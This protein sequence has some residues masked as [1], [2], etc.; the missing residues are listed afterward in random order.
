MTDD[1]HDLNGWIDVRC[2]SCNKLLFRARG[3]GCIIEV[4]CWNR[5]CKALVQ[6]P[7]SRMAEVVLQ[8]ERR[9]I[10]AEPNHG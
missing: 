6:W 7:M 10:I 8:H 9:N 1:G 3:L 5:N 2:P 4:R